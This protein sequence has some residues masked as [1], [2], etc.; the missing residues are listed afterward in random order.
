[1]LSVALSVAQGIYKEGDVPTFIAFMLEGL[2]IA[3]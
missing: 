1:M 2:F 3:S